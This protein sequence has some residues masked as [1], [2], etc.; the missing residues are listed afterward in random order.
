MLALA[1]SSPASSW[2]LGAQVPA[3][4]LVADI[5]GYASHRLRHTRALW[6]FHAVH[7]SA[8]ALDWLAAA[9]MH[10]LD[11]VIDN[12]L[13]GV[14]VLACG[15]DARI[16]SFLGPALILHTMLVHADVAWDFGPLRFV[17]ASPAFHR[18]HHERERAA[19]GCNFAQLF[20]FL[21]AL[22][23]TLYFPRTEPARF[24]L[25]DEPAPATLGAQL[26]WPFARIARRIAP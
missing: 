26:A 3:A 10:P 14:S 19:R 12:V 6:P 2:P 17:L 9:R 21:D 25:A 16:L 22:F 20:P 8:A 13:V 4:L 1:A 15:F 18:W 24:G 5:V 23:G 7:H 11:D